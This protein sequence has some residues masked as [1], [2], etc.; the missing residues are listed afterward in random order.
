MR[1]NQMEVL[2]WANDY[3]AALRCIASVPLAGE[4]GYDGPLSAADALYCIRTARRALAK[5]PEHPES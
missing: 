4:E 1:D 3:R 2:A 5:H